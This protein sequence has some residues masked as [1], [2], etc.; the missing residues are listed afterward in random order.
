MLFKV[1]N[2]ELVK[3]R[4]K[5]YLTAAV[6]VAATSITVRAVDTNA[7]AD[8]DYIIIGEIGTK[9]AEVLQINGAVSDG[10]SLTID[11]NGSGGARYAHAADEP[12][13]RIDY[14][15]VEFSRA[16][17][18]SG[19]KSVL[20]TNEIQADDLFTRYEDASNT[21]GF[22][23]VRFNNQTSAA[24]SAYSDGIN[25]T[26]YTR[27]SLGRMLRA[28]RRLLGDP[29]PEYITD[30]DIIEELDEK[31]RTVAHERLWPFYED[32]F[33]L[34]SVA[35][36]RVY[37]IDNDV[38]PGKVHGCTFKSVPLAK[39]DRGRFDALHWSTANSGD[40]LRFH[41]WNN[42]LELD[43]TPSTAAAT[44]QLNG[45]ITATD[46]TIT[47]DS[48]SGFS[49]S[50][51]I[52]IDSEVIEY[53]NISSTAFRGCR[54]GLEES[55]AAIHSD[56]V[57]V[58]ERDIVYT[59]NREPNELVDIGDETLIPR[60]SVLNYGAAMEI[61]GGKM[62]NDGL[63]DRLKLKFEQELQRL[64]DDFGRKGTQSFFRIKDREE[65]VSDQGSLKN[66]NNPM[67]NTIT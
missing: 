28:V 5:T 26:G 63:H 57:A 44:D 42:K 58:T 8:N 17:T 48:T 49:A 66:P 41:I 3:D 53:T 52:I 18:E 61:A 36:Q 6:A 7:W 59:V 15:R 55:T 46:T 9:T 29:D 51:R 24:F 2:L 22:G 38:V 10:T 40:A 14:N 23:F 1:R 65:V 67:T 16:T 13:Y 19:S 62:Q 43:P 11:N 4:E 27:T 56:D 32:T 60:P 37:D 25:Y 12:V 47:V 45:A 31:Q 34:S 50:G 33:S 54:R 20:A 35:Y 39:I 21:T 64:R 30:E